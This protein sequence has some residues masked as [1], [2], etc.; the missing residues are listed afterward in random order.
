MQPDDVVATSGLSN[1]GAMGPLPVV[2]LWRSRAPLQRGGHCGSWREK[3]RKKERK[4]LTLE[5]THPSVPTRAGFCS[6]RVTHQNTEEDDG[7]GREE[8]TSRRDCIYTCHFAPVPNSRGDA[9][10]SRPI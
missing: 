6:T 9:V 4:K 5:A 7:G 2:V 3:D 10:T 1:V 8:M